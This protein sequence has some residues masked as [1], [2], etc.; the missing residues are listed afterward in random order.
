MKFI[1]VTSE[2]DYFKVI[3]WSNTLDIDN[4]YYVTGV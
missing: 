2:F 4:E 3:D 1:A